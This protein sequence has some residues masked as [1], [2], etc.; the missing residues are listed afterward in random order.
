MGGAIARGLARCNGYEIMVSD[1]ASDKL[2]TL[3]KEC[4]NL[5]TT[6]NNTEAVEWG[7]IIILA[8]KP[9]IL[10]AVVAEIKQAITGDKQIVSIAAG[11]NTEKILSWL[12]SFVAPV[13]YAIPNTAISICESMTFISSRD[14]DEQQL[15]EVVSVFGKL[16]KVMV[17]DEN[18]IPACMAL[19]SCGIAYAMRYAR[20]NVEGA[21][22]LGLRPSDA[23]NI[24]MQTMRGAAQLLEATGA[25]PEAEIDKVTTPGGYTIKGLNTLEKNG[26]TNAVIEALKASV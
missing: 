10:Q 17:V 22:E 11:I 15:D 6:T 7:H 4:E 14:A 26:F 9:W 1:N 24:I 20:A 16:G 25:H 21:V 3:A 2:E 13:Y 8:V 18:D 23:L 5:R 12:G 19:S